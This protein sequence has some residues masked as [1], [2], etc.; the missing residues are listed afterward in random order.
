MTLYVKKHSFQQAKCLVFL[1]RIP[2]D[3]DFLNDV[4]Y[5]TNVEE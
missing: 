3:K 2:H 5:S 1:W 4:K